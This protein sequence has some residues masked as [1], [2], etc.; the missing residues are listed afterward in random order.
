MTVEP[1]DLHCEWC[2]DHLE[3]PKT[4]ACTPAHRAA[5]HRFLNGHPHAKTPTWDGSPLHGRRGESKRA[6]ASQAQHKKPSGWSGAQLS[7]WKA[8]AALVERL[9][10][11]PGGERL[12]DEALAAALPAKQ[13]RRVETRKR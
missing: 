8:R 1:A 12:I 6:N 5:I 3:P 10:H 9:A 7:Y 2:G 13:R 11:F 4:R